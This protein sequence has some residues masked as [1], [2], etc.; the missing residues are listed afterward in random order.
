MVERFQPD[1]QS[2]RTFALPRRWFHLKLTA[3]HLYTVKY[4]HNKRTRSRFAP[5]ASAID[6]VV[7]RHI[8]SL[9]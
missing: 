9:H 1:T 2:T 4:P 7:G 6:S 8:V 3:A 5:P